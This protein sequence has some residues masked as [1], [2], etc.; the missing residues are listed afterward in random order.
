MAVATSSSDAEYKCIII[1]VRY[2]LEDIGEMIEGSMLIYNN[3]VPLTL[4][5]NLSNIEK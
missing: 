5:L 1:W 2:L 3:K 4:P